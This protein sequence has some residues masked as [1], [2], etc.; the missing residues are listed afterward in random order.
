MEIDD[1]KITG[2]RKISKPKPFPNRM[3]IR[4]QDN[5]FGSIKLL[6]AAQM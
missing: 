4:I 5:M 6:N 2:S 3:L 1:V